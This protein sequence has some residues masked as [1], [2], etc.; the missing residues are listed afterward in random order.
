MDG[1]G[2]VSPSCLGPVMECWPLGAAPRDATPTEHGFPFRPAQAGLVTPDL[3]KARM[4]TR[5]MIPTLPVD[6]CVGVGLSRGLGQRLQPARLVSEQQG[7]GRALGR[8]GVVSLGIAG[9]SFGSLKADGTLALV[10]AASVVDTGF[11]WQ[12]Q[13]CV[14]SMSPP[15]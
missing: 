9:D 8:E 14:I 11:L 3:R 13:S 10:L 15:R 1:G 2:A 5:H 4:G 7:Q 12:P 6:L